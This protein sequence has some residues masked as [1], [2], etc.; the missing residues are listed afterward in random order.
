MKSLTKNESGLALVTALLVLMLVSAL[1]AGMFAALLA[2][3]RSHAT[4]RDQSVAYAAAHAGLEKL[5]AG[6][7]ALF[8]T[9]FSPSSVQLGVVDNTPPD[10][11]GFEYTAP[12][13]GV[14]SGYAISFTADAAGNP[15]AL[16]DSDI[17]TGPFEGFKG[18]ITPYTLTVTAR[19]TTGNSEVRLRRELQTVAV[20]VFQ[21]GIF[22]EKTLGFH[23]G[24]NFDFGGRVHTNQSLYLASGDGST[25]T[26]R[27]KITAFVQ[28]VRTTLSNGVG[29]NLTNHEGTVSLPTVIGGAPATYRNLAA[30]E[31]SGTT[32][33][34]VATWKNLSEVTY[35]TNI[36]TEATG[37]KV[38]NLPLT[39]QGAQPV[40][41]IRRPALGNEDVANAAVFG[42]RYF[43]QASLRILLSDRAADITGLPTITAGAP[44][45]LT[46]LGGHA[47]PYV[48]AALRTPVALSPGP[49][50]LIAGTGNSSTRVS[51][52]G[53]GSPAQL[54]IQIYNAGAW[55]AAA[56]VPPWLRHQTATFVFPAWPGLARN[57]TAGGVALWC[58]GIAPGQLLGCNTATVLNQH[59]ALGAGT[60]IRVYWGDGNFQ[61]F[62]TTAAAAAN[63]ATITIATLN[64]ARRYAATRA[65]YI[66]EDPVTCTGFSRQPALTDGVANV[67]TGCTVAGGV[68]PN[69]VLTA[70]DPIYTGA[71]TTAG[72]PLLAGFL[73]IEKQSAAGVWTDVTLELLQ[74]GF[75][76]RPWGSGDVCADPTPNAVIRFQRLRDN[77]LAANQCAVNANNYGTFAGV[78]GF[79]GWSGT[80]FVPN[81]L[82]DARE[83][84]TR[85]LAAGDPLNM[86]GLFGYVAIDVNNFRQWVGGAI[87]TTG[88]LALNN[89]GYIIYFS[90]RRG[91]HNEDDPIT[92]DVETGAYGNEDFINPAAQVWAK[93]NALEAGENVDESVDGAVPPV[94]TLQTY[95]EDPSGVPGVV[96]PTVVWGGAAGNLVQ[97]MGFDANARPWINFPLLYSGRGRLARPVLFRRALKITNG[98]FTGLA[99][100]LPASGLT[101]TAENPIYVQGNYNATAASVTAEP[102]VPAAI[103]GDS[104]TLLSNSFNDAMTFQF[105]NVAASRVATT[106]GYRFAMCTGKAIPFPRPAGAWA[107]NE[108][109]SDGGVHNFM[110]MLENWGGQTLRY[111]GSMVSLYYSRQAIGIY[112][113]DANIYGAPTRAFNFD[114]DFLT[115]ALLPPGTPMFRDINT[116]KFRQILRPN[117]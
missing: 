23:A 44:Y 116:L 7:A 69:T 95:G 102:N 72:T 3:D 24:P 1:M 96:L 60:S 30:N 35:H 70:N 25:L 76:D 16:A 78:G 101:I 33:A 20:P 87:G 75:A 34:P 108:M 47:A 106:T 90:D 18:L 12:G 107:V 83:A 99:N 81:M 46:N 77:G 41:L 113:A 111:R 89:N 79:P 43:K 55:V 17:T 93:S 50:P 57:Q 54:T 52:I 6:L 4:D 49:E 51:V 105:P 67:L 38:L 117:Q 59:P 71:T 36:R 9:D 112:R 11:D 21:F 58:T 61:D 27:D 26:F 48:P 5:T 40:D 85:P 22:G 86:G 91:D 28:V 66:G 13:G 104:V 10:I 42:Q 45:D 56:Q 62:P 39:S 100:N 15:A 73:K 114:T 19:S 14:N 80:D 64:P 32:A 98:G 63:S 82:Y 2:N 103:I 37:A 109:G 29:T 115:P 8:A 68:N 31:G 97:N 92:A 84:S 88:N 110:K 94:P 65:I 74:L 53:G